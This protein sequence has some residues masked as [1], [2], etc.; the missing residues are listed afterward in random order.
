[1]EDSVLQ[2]GFLCLTCYC[3]VEIIRKSDSGI[4]KLLTLEVFG[5]LS[6]A[7][8][9][10]SSQ[11]G[12]KD[13]VILLLSDKYYLPG[14]GWFMMMFLSVALLNGYSKDGTPL[15]VI[16]SF[17]GVISSLLF[18]VGYVFFEWFNNGSSHWSY[19]VVE[20]LGITIF[21]VV[22]LTVVIWAIDNIPALINKKDN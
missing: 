3:M 16:L 22:V 18:A 13:S 5:M 8:L 21:I 7:L 4:A 11:E 15:Q 20:E 10:I 6:F 2:V 14:F 12:G 17:L 1:M 19:V 9:I